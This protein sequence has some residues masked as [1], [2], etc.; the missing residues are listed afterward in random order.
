MH[1]KW[2]YTKISKFRYSKIGK[3]IWILANFGRKISIP[4][5][6]KTKIIEKFAVA[7]CIYVYNLGV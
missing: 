2:I 7:C 6:Q 4:C 3:I 5:I 1:L